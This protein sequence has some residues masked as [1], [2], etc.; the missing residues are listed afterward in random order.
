MIPPLSPTSIPSPAVTSHPIAPVRPGVGVL[1]PP[2]VIAAAPTRRTRY[3]E[4]AVDLGL[5]H[6][7]VGDH[8]SFHVGLGFDGLVHAT[9][10]LVAQS[11]LPVTVAVYLLALRHPVTVARS[12]ASIHEIAPGRLTLG[13]GVGGE[14]RNE[15]AQCGVDPATRGRRTDEALQ[16]LRSLASGER[17]AFRG[18]FYDIDS[19]HIVPPITPRQP[20]VVGGR[21]A[22]ALERA[23][24][25]GDG[26]LGIWVS[27]R[28]FADAIAEVGASATAAGRIDPVLRHQMNVWCGI[29]DD[30]S[31]ARDSV[32]PTMEALYATP[33]DR[34]A[35]Y[36]P[37]GT[38]TAVAEQL[39]AYVDAGCGAF[40]LIVPDPVPE[41][42]LEHVAAVRAELHA[43][44][45]RPAHHRSRTAEE[46]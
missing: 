26:W 27:A 12:L 6:L 32:A 9:T 45:P 16:L 37:T 3:L 10:L 1:V 31:Q 2:E 13:V 25:H 44:A 19:A 23:G 36:V 33:F 22:A 42:A 11:Q 43:A 46:R 7:A 40:N 14:D 39:S 38:P 21:S 41:R 28:R 17:V 34:F 15:I 30:G 24:R 5:D 20:L 8:V 29:A 18:D 35:K 4:S